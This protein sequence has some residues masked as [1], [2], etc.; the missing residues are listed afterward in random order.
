[1]LRQNPNFA[2]YLVSRAL[3]IL[4]G[5]GTAFY[6]LYARR[7]FQVD[8]AFAA[9]LTVAALASQTVFTPLLGWLG[10][11]WGHKWLTQVWPRSSVG[12]R[13]WWPCSR[14]GRLV[15]WG[16]RADERRAPRG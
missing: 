16:L 3:L 9:N 12:R 1:M 14:P 11:Q 13:C 10:A 4:G 15:L 5:M 8:D 6:V 2:R 7:V